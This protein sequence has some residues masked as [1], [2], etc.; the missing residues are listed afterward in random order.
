MNQMKLTILVSYLLMTAYFFTN[1]LKFSLH[2]PTNS[3]EDKFL[4]FV[5]FVITTIFWPVVIVMS[6][7]EILNT[8]K[9]EFRTVIPV[10]LAMFAMSISYYLA[11]LYERGF[12]YNQL[13]CSFPS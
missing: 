9:L 7:W 1:W 10:M 5:M 6:L 4:S 12:C 11:Y 8:R 2:H 13:F 3:P